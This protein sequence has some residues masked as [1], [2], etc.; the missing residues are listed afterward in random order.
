MHRSSEHKAFGF[1]ESSSSP[2][3]PSA[4]WKD[5]QKW[6][7]TDKGGQAGVEDEEG[8]QW[9]ENREVMERRKSEKE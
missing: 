7:E 1:I 8:G 6:R 4:W 2:L 9:E 3:A 5:G